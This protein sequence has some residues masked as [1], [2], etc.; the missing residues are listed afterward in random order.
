MQH[1]IRLAKRAD[2]GMEHA[3]GGRPSEQAEQS[4]GDD[5][6]N[7]RRQIQRQQRAHGE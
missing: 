3:R 7:Q 6:G 5:D 1:K 4:E 2:S